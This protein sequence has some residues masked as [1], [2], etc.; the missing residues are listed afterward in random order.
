MDPLSPFFVGQG[1]KSIHVS[2]LL[3]LFL[4]RPPFKK[5]RPETM[6]YVDGSSSLFPRERRQGLMMMI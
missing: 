5:R 6:C 1:V 4:S 3:L 2:L